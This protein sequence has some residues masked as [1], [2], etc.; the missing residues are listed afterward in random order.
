MFAKAS[1]T[2]RNQELMDNYGH[3]VDGVKH[4]TNDARMNE[5]EQ[6]KLAVL[7]DNCTT[8]TAS[9]LNIPKDVLL[10]AL[11]D[12][13]DPAGRVANTTIS[14]GGGTDPVAGGV[15]IIKNELMMIGQIFPNMISRE[16]VSIQPI[17]QPDYRIFFKDVIRNQAYTNADGEVIPAGQKV[18]EGILGARNY[19]NSK[20][21]A[22]KSDEVPYNEDPI[23][24]DLGLR[25]SS[26]TV[27]TQ[28]KKLRVN[29]TM[30][31]EQDLK[32]YHGIDAMSL[33]TGEMSQEITREWDGDIIADIYAAAASAT[34][35][36]T[37]AVRTPNVTTF[38]TVYNP[39]SAQTESYADRIAWMETFYDA[40]EDVATMIYR[41]RHRRP[42]FMIVSPEMAAFLRKAQGFITEST[43][44]ESQMIKTGGRYY[45]GQFKNMMRIYV[46]TNHK[47][48]LLGY[49]GA[50]DWTDTGYVF[51]PYEMAYIT[52]QFVDPKTLVMTR[53]MMS[54][55][56][57]KVITADLYGLIQITDNQS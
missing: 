55:A 25:I 12:D 46:D 19:G 35:P 21:Y 26:T 49:N 23:I 36:L 22:G 9:R 56:A 2:E 3:L 32:A 38:N 43:G 42:N 29:V 37:G 6:N 4:F 57:R 17:A 54:R 53:A 16:L 50:T 48:V 13:K 7:L 10:K 44:A 30:E 52:P 33:M 8:E 15:Y 40:V 24:R 47:N 18:N 1:F 28:P 31:V 5:L 14:A 27:S 45:A 41:K 51:S 34:D 39:L 11:K 20:E